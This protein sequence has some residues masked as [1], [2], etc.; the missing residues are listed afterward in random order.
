MKK[1]FLLIALL[2]SVPAYAD[3]EVLDIGELQ[4]DA[5]AGNVDAQMDLAMAYHDGSYGL[6]RNDAEAVKWFTKAAEQGDLEGQYN[7][8]IAYYHGYGVKKNINEAVKWFQKA[9]EQGYADAESILASAYQNGTGGVSKDLVKADMWL[10]FA[11]ADGNKNAA[12]ERISLEATMT[13][14]QITAAQLL[15]AAH[16]PNNMSLKQ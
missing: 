5:N 10:G 3:D 16:K 15:I 12:S 14:D 2:L 9:A 8:A 4:E 1:F 7:L 6:K 13:E 11:E